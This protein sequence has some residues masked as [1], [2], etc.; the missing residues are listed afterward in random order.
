MYADSMAMDLSELEELLKQTVAQRDRVIADM[1]FLQNQRDMLDA[2]ITGYER[3]L[4][5]AHGRISAPKVRNAEDADPFEGMAQGDMIPVAIKLAG[6]ALTVNEILAIW[7]KYGRSPVGQTKHSQVQVML[8]N[9]SKKPADI[10]HIGDGKWDLCSSYTDAERE[11]IQSKISAPDS[12]DPI[13]H[14]KRTVEGLVK[15]RKKGTYV[16]APPKITEVQWNFAVKMAAEGK[17]LTDIHRQ[18]EAEYVAPGEKAPSYKTLHFHSP[19]IKRGDPYPETWAKYFE[20]HRLSGN[21]SPKLRV[22]K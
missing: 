5:S 21:D 6:K 12:R 15:A 11:V 10:F 20:G 9:R 17:K 4:R 1:E 13:D 14:K 7:D 19:A 8:R 22:V 2:T 3:M 16:G 18:I